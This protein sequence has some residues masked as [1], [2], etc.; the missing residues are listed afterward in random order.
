[1]GINKTQELMFGLISELWGWLW[2]RTER[3]VLIIGLDNA[4][5]TTT[6]EA[7]KAI[8]NGMHHSNTPTVSTVGLN[9]A[10]I[11]VK[12]DTEVVIWDVGG[13]AMLQPLW[14]SYYKNADS[15]LFVLDSTDSDRLGE[16]LETLCTIFND[17]CWVSVLTPVPVIIMANKSEDGL[18]AASID[19]ITARL[20]EISGNDHRKFTP[21][22]DKYILQATGLPVDGHTRS[23]PGPYIEAIWP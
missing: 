12:S 1:M 19:H 16:G 22:D 17:P 8:F 15:I 18:H 21:R 11:K 23:D 7:F 14:R 20:M 9:L 13:Q 3:R 10:R 5:K 4:G 6:L 2:Q